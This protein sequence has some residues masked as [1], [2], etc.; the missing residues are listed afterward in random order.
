MIEVL[1]MVMVFF[2]TMK[3]SIDNKGQGKVEFWKRHVKRL[4]F[5][6]Q[7]ILISFSLKKLYDYRGKVAEWEESQL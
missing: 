4:K 2:E 3:W 6:C 7:K 1:I 5:G